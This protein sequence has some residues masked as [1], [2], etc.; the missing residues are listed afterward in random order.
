MVRRRPLG[1]ASG[2]ARG[3]EA[4]GDRGLVTAPTEAD[5]ERREGP[6]ALPTETGRTR[7]G[8][9]TAPTEADGE[10]TGGASGPAH[11]DEADGDRGLV[12]APTRQTGATGGASGPAHGGEADGGWGSG[13]EDR[14]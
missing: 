6:V 3:G 5:G 9:V 12:T 11:G 4:D 13:A 7:R 10:R 1:R 2:P 14:G 8:L